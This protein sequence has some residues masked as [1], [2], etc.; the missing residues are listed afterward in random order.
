MFWWGK[1]L[2]TL[3]LTKSPKS[4]CIL[5]SGPRAATTMAHLLVSFNG[6][7]FTFSHDFG[8]L[9]VTQREATLE[10]LPIDVWVR[11]NKVDGGTYLWSDSHSKDYMHHFLLL[12]GL[13]SYESAMNY[14]KVIKSKKEINASFECAQNEPSNHCWVWWSHS[15]LKS[16]LGHSQLS[17]FTSR[18]LFY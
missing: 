7:S 2:N 13:S 15:R 11:T 3:P 10:G 5:L 6:T 12:E 14:K 8:H 1:E 9:L 16:K 4:L 18:A 17:H